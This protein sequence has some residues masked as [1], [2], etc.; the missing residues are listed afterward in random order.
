TSTRPRSGRCSWSCGPTWWTTPRS[1]STCPATTSRPSSPCRWRSWWSAWSRSAW[2][3]RSC[4]STSP[5]A[6][7]SAPSRAEPRS[8]RRAGRCG[9]ISRRSL[10]SSDQVRVGILGLG[11]SGWNIHAAG[12]RDLTDQFRVVAVADALAERREEAARDFG[13]ATYT[14]PE[15]LLADDQ[16]ELVVVATP[17]HTH[18]PLG[19]A[20]LQAGKHVIVEKPMG[21]TVED[22][23]RLTEAA[24]AAGKVVT[25][26]QNNRFEP[27]LLR[28]EEHTSELQSRE[29]LVCHLLLEKTHVGA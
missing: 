25:C 2:S 28:S 22:I 13:A 23:D 24:E 6:C 12:L 9:T 7:S 3:T 18:V 17:S 14:E 21:E 19:V 27:S 1:V 26:F 10:L 5:R 4:R 11:R 20:A 29:K 16:V 8:S 15:Q